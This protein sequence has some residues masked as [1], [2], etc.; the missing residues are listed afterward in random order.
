MDEYPSKIARAVTGVTPMQLSY[1]AKTGLVVPSVSPGRGRGAQRRYSL[2][3]L[4]QL[5]VVGRL[6]GAGISLQRVRKAVAYLRRHFPD[7]SHPL[8]ELT[9]LTDGE[10]VFHLTADPRVIVDTVRHAGQLV[11]AL[12]FG[13]LV[14]QVRT[15]LAAYP[16]RQTRAVTVGNFEFPV[17]LTPDAEDGG[18]VAECPSLPG[19]LSQGETIDEA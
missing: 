9:L 3:D 18:Y 12:A 15:K 4:V 10:S 17:I 6:L 13:E 11:Y 19:C 7:L 14:D 2:R 5:A 8:A 16:M 1:W